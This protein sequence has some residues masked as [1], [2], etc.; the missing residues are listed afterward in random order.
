MDWKYKHFTQ[1]TFFHAEPEIVREAVGAFAKDWL[2]D[3]GI[4][5]TPDGFEAQGYSGLHLATAKFRVEAAPGGTKVTVEMQVQRASN[6]GFMLVDIGGFYNGEIR[7]WLQ[8][9]P[10]WVR[11]KEAE[12]TQSEGQ[13]AAELPGKP[14]VPKMS[15]ALNHLLGCGLIVLLIIIALWACW[16][17]IAAMIGLVTGNLDLPGRGGDLVLHG[18]W[19]RIVSALILLLLGWIAFRILKPKS[20]DRGSG[21]LPPPG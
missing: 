13:P 2:A 10:W 14:P 1:D 9:L 15:P 19:A 8:A 3:W 12:A 6:R 5:E 21:W 20:R 16:N 4:S 18:L 11:Q 17:F 7:R